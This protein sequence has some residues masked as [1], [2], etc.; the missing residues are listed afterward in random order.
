MQTPQPAYMTHARCN[1]DAKKSY[2]TAPVGDSTLSPDTKDVIKMDAIALTFHM[3]LIFNT[4]VLSV[5]KYF[6]F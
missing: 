3:Q 5:F 4:S 1:N 6:I 2:R